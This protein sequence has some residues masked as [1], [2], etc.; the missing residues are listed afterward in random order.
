MSNAPLSQSIAKGMISSQIGRGKVVVESGSSFFA[1]DYVAI[2]R[3]KC[4][5][6][7]ILLRPAYFKSHQDYRTKVKNEYERLARLFNVAM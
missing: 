7:V 5:A 3:A 1:G 4:L 2:S 6:Q